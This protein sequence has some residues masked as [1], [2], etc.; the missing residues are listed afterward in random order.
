MK[1]S[2]KFNHRPKFEREQRPINNIASNPEG[3]GGLDGDFDD[4]GTNEHPDY[5]VAPGV[6]IHYGMEGGAT[7]PLIERVRRVGAE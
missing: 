2:P 1:P 4:L 7:A 5:V 3:A 6:I